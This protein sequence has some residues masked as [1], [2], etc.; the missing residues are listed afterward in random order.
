MAN[1]SFNQVILLGNLGADPTIRTVNGVKTATLSLATSRSW[2]SK[3]G[4][5]ASRTDWHRIV[6]WAQLAE[7]VERFARK[8]SRVQVIGTL[9]TRK[10]TVEGDPTPR[11][12]VEVRAAEVIFLDATPQRTNVNPWDSVPQPAEME[13]VG[14]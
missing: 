14:A 1:R 5:T 10:Y 2:T 11:I 6:V 4:T 3:D 12:A 9:E 7:I 13:E 8:G